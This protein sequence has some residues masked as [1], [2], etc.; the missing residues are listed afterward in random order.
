MSP[1]AKHKQ[2]APGEVKDW[3]TGSKGWI[4]W[5]SLAIM[6]ADALVSLGWLVLRPALL[7]LRVYGAQYYRNIRGGHFYSPLLGRPMREGYQSLDIRATS[8][9]RLSTS[10]DRSGHLAESFKSRSNDLDE[11]EIDAPPEQ[12]VSNR[13]FILWALVSAKLSRVITIAVSC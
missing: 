4:V 11:P 12:L 9:T 3:T 10:Q 1:L 6:L 13:S 2:W 8:S 5:V 7:Y